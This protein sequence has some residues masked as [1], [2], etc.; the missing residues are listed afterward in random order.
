M[1]LMVIKAMENRATRDVIVN[2]AQVETVDASDGMSRM[3]MASGRTIYTETALKPLYNM[4]IMALNP[5]ME[6]GYTE[7][8]NDAKAYYESEARKEAQEED[9][10][11][12]P[13]D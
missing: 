7:G 10:A 3:V 1:K 13:V 12:E 11:H 5:E 8:L 9:G 4:W 2:P 6:I